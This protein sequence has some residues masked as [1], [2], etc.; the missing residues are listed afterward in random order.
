MSFF[1]KNDKILGKYCVKI[2]K[3]IKKEFD[4]EPGYNDEYLNTKIKS[5][6]GKINTNFHDDKVPKEDFQ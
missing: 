6:E 2:S 1:I 5:Y 4:T 3:V